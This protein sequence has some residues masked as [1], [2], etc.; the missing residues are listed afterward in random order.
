MA[1]PVFAAD[2]HEVAL[3]VFAADG[4]EVALCSEGDGLTGLIEVERRRGRDPVLRITWPLESKVTRAPQR[5]AVESVEAN[6]KVE[7]NGDVLTTG[8]STAVAPPVAGK[9]TMELG[10]AGVL[11]GWGRQKVLT[12]AGPGLRLD[13]LLGSEEARLDSDVD[14]PFNEITSGS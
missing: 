12:E 6:G 2:G 10:L 3:A 11:L 7:P 8:A 4:H 1:L 13:S 14:R 9:S 5:D